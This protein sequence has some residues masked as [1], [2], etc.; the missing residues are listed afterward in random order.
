MRNKQISGGII[1]SFLSQFIGIGVGLAYTPVMIRILG[2]SEYGLYQLVQSVVSYL[3][4]MNIG[5]NGAY[6]RYFSIAKTK[7]DEKEVAN[8]NGMFFTIFAVLA[9]AIIIGGVILYANIG[10]LGSNLTAADYVTAKKLLVVLVINLAMSMPNGLFTAYIFA[11]ERFVFPKVIGIIANIL[12]PI[13]NLP[14]LLL[15][16]GSVG[17][18]CVTLALT[19][20]QTVINI[21]YCVKRLHIRIHFGYFNKIIFKDLFAFTFFIFLSDLVDQLNT[22]V[23]KLLLGRM[24]GTVAVAI[25]SVAFNLKTHYTTLTWLVPEMYIPEVN[26]VAVEE[27]SDSKLTD[28]FIQIGRYNNFIVLL[29]ITG[30]ILCGKQF[31]YLWVG[32]EYNISYYAAVILMLSGYIPA[33][34][35]LGV[36][37]Q[38]AKNM[39]RVRSFVYFGIACVNVVASVFLIRIWGVV[40]TCL[41]TLFAVLLGS[42]VFMNIYYHKRI[43]LD[44]LKFWKEILKSVPYCAI[45]VVLGLLILRYFSIDSWLAFL[46]FVGVYTAIYCVLLF[47]LGLKK[48]ERD[49]LLGKLKLRKKAV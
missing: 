42:G 16:F 39:H 7:N 32:E 10:I 29:V 49:T 36:N 27:K 1:L 47:V 30:F 14:L 25:Y 33:V 21:V 45:A 6:I 46:I 12:I 23:D 13:L 20:L 18:V 17:M 34:Q 24:S 37:I 4:L 19:V 35:T 15:G 43:G 9:G 11:N 5:F 40:G 38:N 48:E 22:N 8:I 2:Q 44:V 31:I 3:T 28:L 41:G 26:R